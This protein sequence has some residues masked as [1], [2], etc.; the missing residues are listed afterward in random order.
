MI[1]LVDATINKGAPDEFDYTYRGY[2]EAR[3]MVAHPHDDK[4]WIGGFAGLRKLPADV[5]S[6]VSL[7]RMADDDLP[8][9]VQR[10]DVRLIDAVGKNPNLDFVLHDTVR[11]VEQLRAEAR[12]VFLCVQAAS[13]TPTVAAL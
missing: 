9:G 3:P 12:T 1:Q 11:A 4:V 8:D 10:L 5:D 7:C 2:P 6:V 13:R